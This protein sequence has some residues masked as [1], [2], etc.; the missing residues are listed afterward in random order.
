MQ[1]NTL[2]CFTCRW[3]AQWQTQMFE[4]GY[5]LETRTGGWRFNRVRE[6]KK[7]VD[8]ESTVLALVKGLETL[9][10]KEQVCHLDAC[11][12]RLMEICCNSKQNRPLTAP[13][14]FGFFPS[15]KRVSII[16]GNNGKQEKRERLPMDRMRIHQL[17]VNALQCVLFR[18]PT[19][20]QGKQAIE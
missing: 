9:V 4:K 11:S 20:S 16:F 17:Q 1:T 10:T 5:G 6:D 18:S 8:E 12:A 15:W 7:D 2:P 19:T 14:Y 13:C 3:D